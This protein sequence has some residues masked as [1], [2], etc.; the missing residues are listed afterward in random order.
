MNNTNNTNNTI[1]SP[2]SKFYALLIGINYYESVQTYP[3]RFKNLSDCV[4]NVN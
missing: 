2:K 3:Q 4:R 1:E